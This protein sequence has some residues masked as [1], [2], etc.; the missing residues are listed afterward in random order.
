MGAAESKN[1][2]SGGGLGYEIVE[3]EEPLLNGEEDVLKITT[4]NDR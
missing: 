1:N 2:G 4:D 3:K